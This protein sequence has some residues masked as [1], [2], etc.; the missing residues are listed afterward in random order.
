MMVKKGTVVEAVMNSRC[1]VDIPCLCRDDTF[2]KTLV[3]AILRK[4]S[5]TDQDSE[6]RLLPLAIPTSKSN[7][8]FS[9]EAQ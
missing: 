3:K 4:C 9:Q 6:Q 7:A 1:N 8:A 2:L 5:L